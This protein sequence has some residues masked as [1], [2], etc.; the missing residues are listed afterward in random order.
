MAA[1][2][3]TAAKAIAQA[4]PAPNTDWYQAALDSHKQNSMIL[5]QFQVAMSLEPAFHFKA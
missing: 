2:S 1:A 5:G 4:P 3:L